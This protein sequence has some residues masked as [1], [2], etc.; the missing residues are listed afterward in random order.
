[1]QITKRNLLI[2]AGIVLLVLAV[3]FRKSNTASAEKG[4]N[5]MMA[6]VVEPFEINGG[7]GYKVNMDGHTYIYQDVIP[8]IQGNHVFHSREEAVRV[9]NAVMAKL[10]KHQVPSMS[11]GELRQMNINF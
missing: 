3:I 9:G 11:E 10:S 8:G 7:W 2:V 4:V 6:V 1:M 5:A